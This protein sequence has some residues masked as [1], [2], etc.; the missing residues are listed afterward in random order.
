MFRKNKD[1]KTLKRRAKDERVNNPMYDGLL[2][3]WETSVDND[4]SDV[5]GSYTG[6]P[7]EGEVPEQDAD[8]I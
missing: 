3:L 8:D 5:L 4:V 1:S 6:R 7:R 2:S